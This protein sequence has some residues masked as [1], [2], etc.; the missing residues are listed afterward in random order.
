[1]GGARSS[2]KVCRRQQMLRQPHHGTRPAAAARD[3]PGAGSEIAAIFR[4]TVAKIAAEPF[5]KLVRDCGC[6]GW[7]KHRRGARVT[8]RLSTSSGGA[9]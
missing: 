6:K 7:T 4:L 2:T 8:G 9:T 1:V 5:G 3:L